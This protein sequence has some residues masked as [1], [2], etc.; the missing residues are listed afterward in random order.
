LA[1]E[2]LGETKTSRSSQWGLDLAKKMAAGCEAKA[3][4]MG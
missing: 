3:K 4:E 1:S 2:R